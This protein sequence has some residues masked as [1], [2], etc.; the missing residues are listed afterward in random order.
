MK[1]L[2]L[3]LL[4][5]NGLRAFVPEFA[6]VE[7]ANTP[8]G[9]ADFLRWLPAALSEAILL[10]D[11]SAEEFRRES[12]P[13]LSG[14]RHRA[15]RQRKLDVFFRGLTFRLAERQSRQAGNRRD[16]W[17][18]FSALQNPEPLQT[19][20]EIMQSARIPLRGVYSLA[21]LGS[22]L[23]GKATASNVL[24]V[25][26][27][28]A[29]GLR[30]SYFQDGQLVFSRLTSSIGR[31]GFIDAISADMQDTCRYLAS[32][33]MLP[34]GTALQIRIVGQKSDLR[35]LRKRLPD[36]PGQH[37]RYL[38]LETLQRHF[39]IGQTPANSDATSVWLAILARH[40]PA[41]SYAQPVHTRP[42]RLRRIGRHLKHAGMAT[43]AL[44][45]LCTGLF[46]WQAAQQ[47]KKTQSL[48]SLDIGLQREILALE[49]ELSGLPTNPAEMRTTVEWARRLEQENINPRTFLLPI[50][51]IFDRH[52]NIMLDELAWQAAPDVSPG[53]VRISVECHIDDLDNDPRT[54]QA[55]FSRFRADLAEAMQAVKTLRLP[56]GSNPEDSLDS[57]ERDTPVSNH[58]ALEMTWQRP[59]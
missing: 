53:S 57:L 41:A 33:G 28:S 38:T 27:Q 58:F 6:P 52:P 30:Q 21:R 10:I 3:M 51:R 7:F 50:S 42:Y 46:Y 25:S 4:S 20:L 43:L 24:L 29:S 39:G 5:E 59:G 18:L 23:L 45:F 36:S 47:D 40:Q 13:H 55:Q 11:L 31:D 15:L 14:Q 34:D 49:A 2:L 9:H 48:Q 17:L 22:L 37:Y 16:D 44:S 12:A 26:W 8:T 32:T 54:A 35:E 1:N 56:A 19:W